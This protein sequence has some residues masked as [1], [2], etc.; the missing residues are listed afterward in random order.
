MYKT[1][2]RSL[3]M[4]ERFLKYLDTKKCILLDIRKCKCHLIKL[5]GSHLVQFDND[6]FILWLSTYVIL[7]NDTYLGIH[8]KISRN[9]KIMLDRSFNVT[10]YVFVVLINNMVI[11]P[12]LL[13]T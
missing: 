6:Y 2:R 1:R 7:S 13:I 11:F 9:Q 10:S 12:L 4:C 5:Q 3:N 8:L